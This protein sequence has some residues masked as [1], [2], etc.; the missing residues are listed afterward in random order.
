[1]DKSSLIASADVAAFRLT[2]PFSNPRSIWI[3]ELDHSPCLLLVTHTSFFNR[4]I[5]A[6]NLLKEIRGWNTMHQSTRHV[7]RSIG[8]DLGRLQSSSLKL[9]YPL[10]QLQFHI[11][12]LT[13]ACLEQFF[14]WLL[15]LRTWLTPRVSSLH[16][17][18]LQPIFTSLGCIELVDSLSMSFFTLACVFCFK[19]GRL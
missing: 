3:S 7:F 17:Y 2:R 1:M 13:T 6:N 10:S 5:L 16:R 18:I 19:F 12:W 15:V 9:V 4:L 14:S 11:I 8:A